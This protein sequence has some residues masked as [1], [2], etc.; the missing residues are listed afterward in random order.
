[1]ELR[2]KIQVVIS[3]KDRANGTHYWLSSRR[4]AEAYQLT[5]GLHDTVHSKTFTLREWQETVQ[6]DL[7]G[8]SHDFPIYVNVVIPD[9]VEAIFSEAMGIQDEYTGMKYHEAKQLAAERGIK[10]NG[11]KHQAIIDLLRNAFVPAGSQI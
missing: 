3:V 6:D 4:K 9:D 11:L 1:M 5:R 10:T 7:L 8:K 2:D